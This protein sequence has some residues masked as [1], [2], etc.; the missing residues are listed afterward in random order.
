[1]LEITNQTYEYLED[2]LLISTQIRITL[3][4]ASYGDCRAYVNQ[5]GFVQQT[6]A[7]LLK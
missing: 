3:H 5:V 6:L 2:R 7:L 1:M 4:P